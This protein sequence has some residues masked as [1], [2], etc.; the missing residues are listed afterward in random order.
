M[1]FE[2]NQFCYFNNLYD[3][4]RFFASAFGIIS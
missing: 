1:F 4:L 2:D 3:I